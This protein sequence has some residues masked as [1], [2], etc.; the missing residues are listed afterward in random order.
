[1][2]WKAHQSLMSTLTND[3]IPKQ[4]EST[5][6][7]RASPG[8]QT[9]WQVLYR[10]SDRTRCTKGLARPYGRGKKEIGVQNS[11]NVTL[12]KDTHKATR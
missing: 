5:H 12:T 3:G 8:S 4:I 10:D 11:S 7:Q 1:M 6:G 2:F 9:S